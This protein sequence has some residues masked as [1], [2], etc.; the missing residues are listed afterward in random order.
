MPRTPWSRHPA[1]RPA[2]VPFD[3][4]ALEGS[5]PRRFEAQADAHPGRLAIGFGETSWTYQ[6]LERS[7]NEVARALLSL[8][9]PLP[10]PVI[11]LIEQGPSLVAAILGVLKAGGIYVPLETTHP[12]GQVATVASEAGAGFVLADQAGA[13]VAADAALSI[14]VVR[15]DHVLAAGGP[16]QRLARPIEPDAPAYIY[17]TSGSTGRPKGVVDTHRNVLHNVMRYTNS[18]GIDRDDRLTLLQSPSFSGAVSSLFGAVLNGAAIFPYDLRRSGTVGLGAW[19]VRERITIYHSVPGLFRLAAAGAA[20]FPDLRLIRL[21]GDQMSRRDWTLFRERF[22]DGCVLVNGLGATEC[23]LV[24]QFFID[25]TMAVPEGVVPIGY[26]VEDME[27]E[28]LDE[29]GLPVPVGDVGEI[30]VRSR[31][32]APG[33]HQRP[34]LT[35]G[36][37]TADRAAPGIRAYRTGDLGRLHPDGCLD[38]LG[39]RDS[40]VKIRGQWV[41]L[42]E[43]EAALLG[44]QGIHE[45][46]ARA[47]EGPA[48]EPRLVAYIVPWEGAVP[49]ASAVRAH[50]A[51]RLPAA[52][53]PASLVTLPRLPLTRNGKIDR[54]ALPLPS[55]QRPDLETEFVA[56]RTGLEWALAAMWA[57]VLELEEIGV[58]DNFFELGGDSLGMSR[59]HGRLQELTGAEV[60]IVALFDHPTIDGM[61][62]VLDGEQPHHRRS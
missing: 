50:L 53:V 37:F 36:A 56:P 3:R 32:L 30:V 17:Y 40:R 48:G 29:A 19:M 60:S 14:P 38:H 59:V 31:Y 33:Y 16:G 61:A 13:A 11:L 52:A 21:E 4:S 28:I 55:T 43:V 39:R 18:L 6:Q 22:H 42:A 8:G 27:V 41:D 35:S 58:H 15:I 62:G 47:V 10:G 5:I 46:A 9:D 51:A 12:A 7:A 26:P 20:A 1:R 2:F 49:A 44:V 23:G 34:D 54:A 45:A 25:R 24:R 57:E